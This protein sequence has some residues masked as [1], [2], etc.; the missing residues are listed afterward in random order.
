[1]RNAFRRIPVALV[2]VK[3][4][5]LGRRPALFAGVVFGLAGAGV[6]DGE[7][8]A[9]RGNDFEVGAIRG[10]AFGIGDE[11]VG[12]I[13]GGVRVFSGVELPE[14]FKAGAVMDSL[15]GFRAAGLVSAVVHDGY[16][17]TDGIDNGAGVGEIHA[18]MGDQ[19]EV[20]RADGVAGTHES[21]F[22]GGGE[23]AE[24]EEAE[25]AEGDQ[26]A[27]GASVLTGVFRPFLFGCAKGIGRGLDAGDGG[28]VL[29]VGG[30]DDD[31]EAGQ[32]DGV[33]GVDDAARHAANG[34]EIGGEVSARDVRVF[35]IEAVVEEFADGDALD[36]FRHAANVIGVK[37]G[38]EHVIKTGDAGVAHGGL[39]ALGVATV[40]ARPPCVNQQRLAGGGNKERGLS[41]FDVDGVDA[42]SA[43][44]GLGKGGQRMGEQKQ[45][46]ET[47][48]Q[49]ED[50]GA[51]K[52]LR[53]VVSGDWHLR[54]SVIDGGLAG[55]T[56][57]LWRLRCRFTADGLS[58]GALDAL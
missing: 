29:A 26:D 7:A 20:D 45:G 2:I 24:I 30:S 17:R 12:A 10:A 21:D 15:P 1:M 32:V 18:V 46:A 41:A 53:G 14:V 38:D 55:E 42:E 13:V 23:V 54:R 43:W 52:S 5:A 28:D 58:P 50:G 11:R 4:A 57:E 35:A 40:V 16:A 27:C 22:L 48:Q 33:A 6:G 37:V 56:A 3:C 44:L 47:D 8:A 34:V 31:A 51:A 39:D 9:G 19:I 49:G 25:F 36:E